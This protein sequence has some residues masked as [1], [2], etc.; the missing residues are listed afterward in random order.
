MTNSRSAMQVPGQVTGA[1]PA[2]HDR[3]QPTGWK[4]NAVPTQYRNPR[5]F[6]APPVWEREVRLIMRDHS[7]NR[8][9]AERTF[10]QVIAYLVTSAENSSMP[11]GPAPVVDKGVH[12]F[13]LDTPRY[14]DF[15][16]LHAGRYLHHVP[17][18]PE[19]RAEQPTVLRSTVNAIRDAGFFLDAELWGAIETDCH[20][21]HAGCADSPKG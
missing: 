15:C 18:L 7:M 4:E 21:C 8:A 9:L 16:S 5:N 6:V 13:I 1:T 17:H 19:E 3:Q 2:D 10:A 11:M 12:S 14:W 20:Q